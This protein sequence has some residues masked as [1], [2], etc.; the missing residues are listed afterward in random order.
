[1]ISVANRIIPAHDPYAG[2]PAAN[3]ARSGSSSSNSRSRLAHR[4]R[5]PAG[6]HQR[7]DGIQLGAASHR[8]GLGAGFGKGGQVFS[9]ISLQR[10]DTDA[11]RHVAGGVKSR[12]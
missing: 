1:M 11:R 9:G 12:W 4:G 6:D 10:K 5:L 3:R 2:M 7:I 8:D